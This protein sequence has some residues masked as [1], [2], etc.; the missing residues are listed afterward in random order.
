MQPIWNTR[1][2]SLGTCIAGEKF[3]IQLS[4]SPVFPAGQVSY[5]LLSGSLPVGTFLDPVKIDRYGVISG[6]PDNTISQNLATFTIR[7]T[8]DYNNLTDRTFT[9]TIIEANNPKFTL[10]FGEILSV[11]DSVYVNYSIAYT[12]PI[13][14]NVVTVFVSAGVLPPGL[15]LD[16]L[17][18]ITGYPLGP[19]LSDDSPTEQTYNF[20]V[21]L[22]SELGNDVAIYNITI[23]N[24]RINN[25]PNARVPVI[26]NYTPLIQPVPANDI[27]YDYYLT[28]GKTIPAITAGEYFSFKIIGNDFDNNDIIYQY[29][30]LPP[31]L[32]GNSNTGWITGVP[33]MLSKS[34][35]QYRITVNVAKASNPSIK[36]SNQIFLLT[37]TNDIKQDVTWVT[38]NNLGVIYNGTVSALS[39]TATSSHSLYYRIVAGSL[40]Q[41]LQILDTGEIAGRVAEQTTNKILKQGDVTRYNFT[42]QAYSPDFPLVAATK[43]FTLDVYQ[44]YPTPVENIYFKAS[45]SVANKRIINQLLTDES[46]IPSTLLYRPTD[47]YYGKAKDISFVHIYGMQS[48]NIATYVNAIQ[49]N[50]YWRKITLGEIDTAIATDSNGNILYE[51]VYSKI[52]DPITNSLGQ[53]LPQSIFW[54][55]LIDM[56]AGD[57]TI[58]NTNIDV[59]SSTVHTNLSPG[60]VRYL[61][62]GSLQNMR[63]ELTSKIPQNTD[64]GLL[65]LWMTTQQSS[66]ETL[67]FV[68]AWVICYT[69]PGQSTIIKDNINNNWPYTLNQIDFTIDRFIVDKSAT[70]DWNTNLSIPAWTDLPSGTPQP[71]PLNSNDFSILFP[72]KTI[73]PKDI[74]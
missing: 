3:S 8:D 57:W 31:G 27:Y 39:L 20:A 29:G 4:A 13:P 45:A 36:S 15:Y 1:A 41:N 72:R 44:Y 24:Q 21:E 35:S 17:G 64:S 48:S 54:P 2:G 67:G 25:P 68:Q 38:N 11:V 12:N 59:N 55:R 7:A 33:V 56:N 61:N 26:L 10:S 28:N 37:V 58:N 42:V 5:I 70:Y 16:S 51:V 46:L 30:D 62:P 66:S 32:T 53:S 71:N 14:S 22:T 73:L 47:S 50:H 52:I 69:L 60:Y 65:P 18:N 43:E 19:T 9:L 49:E 63:T 74:K 6:T 40:P 34:I 23:R